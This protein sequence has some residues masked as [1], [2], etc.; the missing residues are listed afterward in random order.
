MSERNQKSYNTY[1][2]SCYGWLHFML[3]ALSTLLNTSFYFYLSV[4]TA[5]DVLQK[6]GLKFSIHTIDNEACSFLQ[7]DN[8]TVAK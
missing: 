1:S 4:L 3:P 8:Q 5:E 6:D 2:I 7:G